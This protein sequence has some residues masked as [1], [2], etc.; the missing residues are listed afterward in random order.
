MDTDESEGLEVTL[1]EDYIQ[2]YPITKAE[3]L[4]WIVTAASLKNIKGQEIDLRKKIC[5]TIL[6][7]VVGKQKVVVDDP[8]F[9]ITA[10][11]GVSL[12]ADMQQLN[13]LAEQKLLTEEDLAVFSWGLKISQTIHH[14]PKESHIWKAITMKPATPTLKVTRKDNDGDSND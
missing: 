13:S 7:E 14:L 2:G 10:E 3:V 4:T 9:K 12:E 1:G 11:I 5:E 8:D 6:G